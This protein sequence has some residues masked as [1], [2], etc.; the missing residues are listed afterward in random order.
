MT[1]R[2]APQSI[3]FVLAVIAAWVVLG[4]VLYPES[5][6]QASLQGLSIWWNLVFPALFPFLVISEMLIAR[7]AVHALG[8][9]ADPFTRLFYRVSGVGGWAVAM[10]MVA[11]YPAGAKITADLRNKGLI[12]RCEAERLLAASHIGNPVFVVTVVAIGFLHRPDLAAFLLGIHYLSAWAAGWLM[13]FHGANEEPLA[14]AGPNS[15]PDRRAALPRRCLRAWRK[16]REEDGRGLGQLLGDAVLQSIQTLLVIGGYIMIF[17]VVIHAASIFPV[18]PWV[19]KLLP[20]LLE[21]TLGAYHAGQALTSSPMLAMATAGA[22][23]GWSGICMQLQVKSLIKS[24]DLRF[25]PFVAARLLHGLLAALLTFALWP[26]VGRWIGAVHTIAPFLPPLKNG[27]IS[28]QAEPF[29]SIWTYVP[30]IA[31]Y[32]LVLLCLMAVLGVVAGFMAKK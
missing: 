3:T 31:A 17:S 24:T 20:G 29:Y 8:V 5:A 4:I 12:G 15:G 23:L 22:I 19:E 14:A 6:F 26:P 16:G 25:A 10:G 9:L 30:W 21:V 18:S 7:G 32:M 27:D 1:F 11:G 13:R 28:G 2:F